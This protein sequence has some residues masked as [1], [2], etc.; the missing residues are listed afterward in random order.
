MGRG[1]NIV[2][3]S[4]YSDSVLFSHNLEGGSLYIASLSLSL[5]L[6]PG[7]PHG[8]RRYTVW[9]TKGTKGGVPNGSAILGAE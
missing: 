4:L 9:R 6:A 5:S 2:D 1:E 3:S 8:S 7:V